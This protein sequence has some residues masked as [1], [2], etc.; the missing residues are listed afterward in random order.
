MRLTG[1]TRT[2]SA[3]TA[4]R[5]QDQRNH[6]KRMVDK[7][8]NMGWFEDPEQNN[9]RHAYVYFMSFRLATSR[10][11]ADGGLA[12]STCTLYRVRGGRDTHAQTLT[13][14]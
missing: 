11:V 1:K 2:R 10:L 13:A 9:E 3:L 14:Y 6:G 12:E 7:R 4:L 5:L 8:A